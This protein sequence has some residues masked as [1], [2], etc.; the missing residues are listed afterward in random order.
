MAF[1]PMKR[2]LSTC[3]GP[4]AVAGV[5]IWLLGC[6]SANKEDIAATVSVDRVKPAGGPISY[7]SFSLLRTA[8]EP[9][10]RV[11]QDAQPGL[12]DRSWQRAQRLPGISSERYWLVPTQRGV[13]LVAEA[14]GQVATSCAPGAIAVRQGVVILQ[15]P[16]EVADSPLTVA[17]VI[18]GVA[19][20]GTSQVILQEPTGKTRLQVGNGGVFQISDR[21]E[22]IPTR[23]SLEMG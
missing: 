18:V 10:P 23:V 3:L 16:P 11:V 14:L 22:E 21:S 1:D 15:M 8:P 2:L 13:C 4:A 9:P 6:G 7:K 17:R 19:P 20:D 5:A 12:S